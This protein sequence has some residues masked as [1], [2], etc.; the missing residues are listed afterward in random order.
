MSQ[1]PQSSAARRRTLG[2][3]LTVA[4]AS[5]VGL[6]WLVAW[7]AG[8]GDLPTGRDHYEVR[9]AVPSAAGLGVGA[10]VTIAGL[11]VGRLDRIQRNGTGA[12]LSLKLDKDRGPLPVD[13]TF[14]VRLRSLVGENYVELYPGRS[15]RTVADGGVL[16]QAQARDYVDVDKILDVLRGETRERA[17]QTIRGLGDGVAGRSQQLNDTLGGAGAV[18]RDAAPVLTTVA[19]NRR[20]V[21]R[22]VDELGQVSAAIGQRGDSVRAVASGL[23]GTATAIAER[24]EAVRQTL[25]RFPDTL[26]QLRRTTGI[27]RTVSAHATPVVGDLATAVDDLGPAIELLHPAAEQGRSLVREIGRAAPPLTGTLA[28]LTKLSGPAVRTLPELKA[29]LCQLNPA[30]RYLSPY[31]KELSG[32]LQAMGSATNFYDANGHAARLFASVGTNS[33]RLLPTDTSKFLQKLITVGGASDLYRIGYNPFPAPGQA[34][35]T[36]PNDGPVGPEDV[37]RPYPRIQAD[38]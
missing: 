3:V 31:S 35:E 24:D 10:N 23:R 28:R 25:R 27:L 36:A 7:I 21:S 34:G 37:K 13:S 6:G 4:A 19:Q 33:A 14:G 29:T 2:H 32:V 15:S 17:R 30:L 12:M 20:Q 5:L 8:S 26:D 38:C 18:V 22:L 16:P 9:V 1:R 11:D